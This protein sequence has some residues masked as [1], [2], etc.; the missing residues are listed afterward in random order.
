MLGAIS[1]WS[2]LLG[3]AGGGLGAA[4]LPWPGGDDGPVSKGDEE[5]VE[6]LTQWP[7]VDKKS[8]K[9][10]LERLRKARTPEMGTQAAAALE[11]MGAGAA[12]YLL[13]KYG[14]E[15]NEDAVARMTAVLEAVTG[16]AHTRLLAEHFA[17]K[18]AVTRTWCLGRVAL[19]PDPGVRAAAEKAFEAADKRKRKR[20]EHE[21]YAAACCSVS[22]GS[23][24]GF[25]VLCKDAEKNWKK[26]G[27]STHIAL[28]AVRGPRAT[29]R[30]VPLLAEE[31]R[32]TRVAAL[33]LLAA[34][35]DRE[36][37]VPL[38]APLLDDSDNSLRVGAINALRGIIDGDP[39]LD[40]LPVF[41]AIERAKKWKARL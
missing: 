20:D 7:A 17:S 27:G 25:E 35:G 30:I 13:A 6:R 38:V 26:H 24:K 19:Y 37:A 36:G 40:R 16:A 22:S 28:T 9:F 39:P 3:T 11:A 14:K 1:L 15:R 21:V 12:P 8:V 34:C 10:E 29:E 4:P 32:R 31:N 5:A 33:R 41:E 23:F 2:A 18:D